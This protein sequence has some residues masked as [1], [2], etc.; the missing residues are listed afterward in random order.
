MTDFR[1]IN[2]SFWSLWWIW[3]GVIITQPLNYS[4]DSW[5]QFIVRILVVIAEVLAHLP[6]MRAKEDN[7]KTPERCL[8]ALFN[9]KLLCSQWVQRGTLRFKHFTVILQFSYTF[10][11][12]FF[13]RQISA[14]SVKVIRW[15][16]A[17]NFRFCL[18]SKIGLLKEVF[19][20]IL[21]AM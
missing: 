18:H 1:M 11:G 14:M 21:S 2:F 3:N 20:N 5:V 13:R 19:S 6:V 12:M 10:P 16:V 17:L 4:F 9:S 7:F 15:I 8:S